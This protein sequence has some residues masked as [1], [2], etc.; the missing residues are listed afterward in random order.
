MDDAEMIMI[1]RRQYRRFIPFPGPVDD[2]T[3]RCMS[4]G[5]I[6]EPKYHDNTCCPA[7]QQIERDGES[8][9]TPDDHRDW[10]Q[11][12]QAVIEALTQAKQGHAAW[13][14][15]NSA[16]EGFAV[17]KEEV[18]ELWDWVKT[19]QRNRDLQAMRQ[20]AIQIAAMALRFAAEVSDERRGRR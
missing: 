15:L 13:K 16:H 17:L 1:G 14:P 6:D 10:A 2:G 4:C 3:T 11:M 18:D 5:Q 12:D 19:K 20:E 9:A 7:T 8:G